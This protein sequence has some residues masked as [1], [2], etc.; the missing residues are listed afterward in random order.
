MGVSVSFAEQGSG[1][2]LARR[3]DRSVNQT[4]GLTVYC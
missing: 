2:A 4:L 1:Q 3:F